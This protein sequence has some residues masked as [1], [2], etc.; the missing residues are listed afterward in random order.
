VI[1]QSDEVFRIAPDKPKFADGILLR[2]KITC[3][4]AEIAHIQALNEQYRRRGS[5]KTDALMT[6]GERL[7]RLQAI[8]QELSQ[9]AGHGRKVRSI[10]EVKKKHRSRLHLVKKVS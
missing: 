10:E 8:Q 5:D 1:D 7:E 2:Q 9:P 4:R 3:L 6:H